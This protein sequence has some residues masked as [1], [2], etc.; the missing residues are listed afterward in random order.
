MQLDEITN[1]L[2]TLLIDQHYN[3]ITITFYER[4]WKKIKRFL[5]EEYGNADYDME[6][7]LSY[8]EKQYG[9][10]SGYNDGTLSQQRVQLLRVVHML[11][12]YSLHGILT[13]R[14]HASRNPITLN[15]YYGPIYQ[16]YLDILETSEL[17]AS[18]KHHYNAIP[19]L[20]FHWSASHH[21]DTL[22]LH[23]HS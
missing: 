18:T 5:I 17:S 16:Q 7:G 10:I 11:E 2:R 22:A 15:D 19:L 4:E 3:L 21:A 9:I 6:L 12:D 13:R 1:G 20:H 23:S 14:Y 8:L